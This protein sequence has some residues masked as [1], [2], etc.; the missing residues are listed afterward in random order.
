[1]KPLPLFVATALLLVTPA[2]AQDDLLPTQ[3]ARQY[4]AHRRAVEPGLPPLK[5]AHG[6]QYFAH[7]FN[8]GELIAARTAKFCA[9]AAP[10]D[11]RRR[12]HCGPEI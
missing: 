10:S 12:K 1:M 5:P 4:E 11:P 3:Q 8:L 2:A 9:T 7:E 6:P